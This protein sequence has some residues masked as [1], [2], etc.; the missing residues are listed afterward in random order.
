MPLCRGFS[1]IGPLPVTDTMR[2][3]ILGWLRD[4]FLHAAFGH[5]ARGCGR[6][7]R[8][9]RIARD[10]NGIIGSG[11]EPC[12]RRPR[13][14]RRFGQSSK[15][16]CLRQ[17]DV[18]TGSMKRPRCSCPAYEPSCGQ[19]RPLIEINEPFRK[20]SSKF[21]RNEPI[22]GEFWMSPDRIYRC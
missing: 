20:M 21:G 9:G 11:A 1:A 7:V 16:D 6:I 5:K 4:C 15:Q 8:A 13:R 2:L 18:Q 12:R 17:V 22:E 14:P 3:C 19:Q 10:R